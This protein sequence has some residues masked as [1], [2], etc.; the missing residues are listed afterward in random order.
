LKG[1]DMSE[2]CKLGIGKKTIKIREQKNRN[3]GGFYIR[4][5]H[6]LLQVYFS[7]KEPKLESMEHI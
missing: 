6:S 5:F 7:S 3:L 4:L 2:P 1:E